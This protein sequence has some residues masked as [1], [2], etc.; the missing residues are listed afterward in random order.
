MADSSDA[1]PLWKKLNELEAHQLQQ[2]SSQAEEMATMMS[3][4]AD[5]GNLASEQEQSLETS[6]GSGSKG[7]DPFMRRVEWTIE[8][9][10]K[11]EGGLAKGDSLWSPKFRAAGMDDVQLEFFPKGREKTTFDGFCSLFLWCPSGSKV[12]YQLWVGSFMRAP[13]EDEFP[14]RIGHGH[15]NFCPVGPEVEKE[16]DRLV[17]GVN[18]L[19]VDAAVRIVEGKGVRLIGRS[20]EMLVEKEAEVMTHKAVNKVVWRIPRISERIRT[21]PQGSSMWSKVFT[22]AGIREILLEFYPNGSTNT[23]KEGHCGFYIRCP[24]GVSMTVTLFV[25]K[26]QKGPIKTTFDS[27]TGKGLPDFCLLDEQINREDDSLEVGIELQNQPAT[28][29][30][31]VT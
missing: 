6:E 24:E 14:G 3:E 28:T 5:L 4:L 9:Y 1:A 27:L 30:T 15:S 2:S 23:T 31:I 21:L 11:Q 26:C 25:G 8:G 18:F 19:E 10:S 16:N 20:L 13:D 22:A 7:T 29:M 17:V 12:K